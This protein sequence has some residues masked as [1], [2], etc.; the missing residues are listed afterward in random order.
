MTTDFT[1]APRPSGALA[2]P[3]TLVRS[4]AARKVV[5]FIGAGVSMAV[6]K[7]GT[8]TR[9]YPSWAELLH[10]AAERLRA[11]Q[12]RQHA[13]MVDN[14]IEL[15]RPK[16]FLEAA[17]WARDGLGPAWTDFLRGQFEHPRDSVDEASL[18]LAQLVWGLRCPVIVTTNY[19]KV[20]QWACPRRDDLA[21]WDIEAPAE[22]VGLLREEVGR[23]VVWHLH[24]HVDNL[25]RAILEPE[26]YS[27]LYDPEHPPDDRYEAALSTL[28][29]QLASRTFLFIGFSFQDE[30]F[31]AQLRMIER[32]YEGAA[33][34]HYVLVR[35]AEADRLVGA[36]SPHVEAVVYED[37]GPPLLEALRALAAAAAPAAAPPEPP[38]AT[39][40]PAA[41]APV[42]VRIPPFHFGSVVPLDFFI[43]R[44]EEL[45]GARE[46][47]ATLQ[48]FLLVGHRRAGKTSFGQKL[49]HT[50]ETTA[51]T[52]KGRVLGCTIDLQ[53]YSILDGSQFLAH[54]LLS[55]IGEAARKVFLCQAT[56]LSQRDPFDSHSELR[57]DVAFHDLLGLYRAAVRRTHTKGGITPSELRSDEFE[58][59]VNDLRAIL[60]TKGWSHCVLFFDE[61]NRLPLDLEV[62][63]LRWNVEALNRAGIVSLYAADPQM[64]EKFNPWS[65]REIRIGPFVR[66][67]DLLR[68]LTR[69]Y[70]GDIAAEQ[71]LPIDGTAVSRIWDLSRGVPYLIQN[72]SGQAFACANREGARRVGEGHVRTAHTELSQRRPDLFGE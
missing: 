70:F 60:V 9:L 48:S 71:E 31:G 68:L 37:H 12:R 32:V 22:Q 69:Y 47:I 59:F 65:D 25:S 21:V 15:G 6:L 36:G 14:L 40:A 1:G 7:R 72:L 3:E 56:T 17:R 33:G 55:L 41:R 53:G 51:S 67:G 18:E 2:F 46:F 23:P 24:G 11:E 28:R 20:L 42:V 13:G 62:Q 49:I 39:A 52:G 63:F 34:P 30:Y 8:S 26:G 27:R 54:T 29:F 5:P 38:R 50:V 10:R 61:A 35:R 45:E 16:H 58:R 4:L 66:M 43:D 57:Q 64:A 19:D 44:E